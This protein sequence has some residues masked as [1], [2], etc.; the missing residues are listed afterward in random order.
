ME[1]HV[2]LAGRGDLATRIYRG[3]RAA[4]AEGRLRPGDRL[5]ATRQLAA[6]LEVA[7]GTVATAYERLVAEGVLVSRVGAGTFVADELP[8]SRPARR[9]RGTAGT[10]RPRADWV[11][12]PSPTSEG[13][14]PEHDFR[15]G[16]PDA[17]LFPFE[18]W[19]RLLV[20]ETRLRANSAGTYAG[21]AGHAGLRDAVARHVG[22]ARSVPA[23]AD[24]VVVT[25][26]TQQALDLVGRVLLAPGDVVAVEE[27]GYPPARALFASLGARV[28]GVPVDA[29]GLAVDALP[30]GAR[31]VYTTPSHQFPLGTAMS[32]ARRAALLAWAEAHDAAIVEDDY[33]SEFRYSERPLDPLASLDTGGRVLYV[34]T[35]SKTM[36]PALRIGFVVAPPSLRPALLAARQLSDGHGPMA[37]QAAL[38]RFMDDGLLA[39]HVRRATAVYAV[40]HATVVGALHELAADL[41][42]DDLGVGLEVVPGA[43]GLHVCAVLSTTSDAGSGAGSGAAEAL[44][45]AVDRTVASVGRRGVALEALSRYC[46]E[47]APQPG[48][49]VGYGAATTASVAPGMAIVAATLR[50]EL[51]RELTRS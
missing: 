42:A 3:L 45:R 12:Q 51:R 22:T 10:L 13:P 47:E 4:V 28:V 14:P 17:T 26:G 46:G 43:A 25:S 33:D 20:G 18:T 19:R 35:F 48:V 34:G 6:R 11:W 24:D 31:L 37:T 44:S 39:R 36:L 5:P 8:A 40:R 30:E 1:L 23:T 27:P 50:R 2:S 21:P 29:E 15:V 38:A 7:R 49:V 32:P 41:H 9:R 16:I